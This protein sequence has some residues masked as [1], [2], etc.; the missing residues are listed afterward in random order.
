MI[1]RSPNRLRI[2]SAVAVVA[3]AC[4]HNVPDKLTYQPAHDRVPAP[5]EWL[6]VSLIVSASEAEADETIVSP[7]E[8][9][10][11]ELL[12]PPPQQAI[13]HELAAR[14]PSRA[15]DA[16]FTL[17]VSQA[18]ASQKM[19]RAAGRLGLAAVFEIAGVAT[20]RVFRLEHSL[21]FH[22][23]DPDQ[24]QR[25]YGQLVAD[26][27][28]RLLYHPDALAA[29]TPAPQPG[30][31]TPT[32]V[33]P[34][35]DGRVGP[36]L[37]VDATDAETEASGRILWPSRETS[38]LASV[39]GVLGEARGFRANFVALRRRVDT[40]FGFRVGGSLLVMSLRAPAI[41]GGLGNIF[42][43]QGVF[44]GGGR[45]LLAGEWCFPLT[46][47]SHEGYV[48]SPG[49]VFSI[50]PQVSGSVLLGAGARGGSLL[51][52]AVE[53]GVAPEA[54][55]PLGD[56]MGITG[57]LLV[58]LSRASFTGAALNA[59]GKTMLAWYPF[60]RVYYQTAGS[61]VSVGVSFESLTQAALRAGGGGAKKAG[62]LGTPVVTLA[63]DG[64]KGRGL[65]YR[66]TERS[67]A[68]PGFP[69]GVLVLATPKSAFGSEETAAEKAE[70]TVSTSPSQPTP[71]S[72]SQTA[73]HV[74]AS[75]PE[76]QRWVVLLTGAEPF[77]GTEGRDLVAQVVSEV[78]TGIGATV[79][80]HDRTQKTLAVLAI[81]VPTVP[82]LPDIAGALDVERA[83]LIELSGDQ[84]GVS[85]RLH[86]FNRTANRVTA[87]IDK[88]ISR[89][90][91]LREMRASISELANA[92]IDPE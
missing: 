3:A 55:I 42:D 66:G 86:R 2:A 52:S 30:K 28:D 33:D 39:S 92:P 65:A 35:L 81:T 46:N 70:T 26:L 84:A 51:L 21:N 7:S 83:L 49:P 40:G 57:G 4:A 12:T 14:L 75:P 29:L 38:N 73:A 23:L 37:E 58:G 34:W 8:A 90:A 11:H 48:S 32:Y 74:R 80:E 56:H 47:R 88:S 50:V 25:L 31:K 10:E 67:A 41:G 1:P 60:A 85:F 64:R 53:A 89:G 43:D 13:E 19:D 54:D 79:V 17:R 27:C 18:R 69:E 91:L 61:R 72:A 9:E 77:L 78:L 20:S 16:P 76:R 87:T 24:Q 45:I 63:Y 36:V 5:D 62:A 15:G 71:H 22:D 59:G 68:P 44:F 82:Q 6:Q